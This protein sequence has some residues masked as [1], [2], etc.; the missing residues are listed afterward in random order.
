[1]GQEIPTSLEGSEKSAGER[2]SQMQ[3]LEMPSR[4]TRARVM[5]IVDPAFPRPG[6]SSIAVISPD[7]KNRSAA[8]SALGE[9]QIGHI[10]I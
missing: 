9:C 1:M 4:L 2:D 5:E 8:L 7:K 6:V 10:E 3:Q